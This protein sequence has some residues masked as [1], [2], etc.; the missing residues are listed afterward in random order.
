MGRAVLHLGRQRH[1]ADNIARGERVNLICWARSSSFRGAAAYGH[2]EPDGYPK[3]AEEG[4]PDRECLS[5]AN[6]DDYA[7]QLRA[8]GD[9]TA[10]SRAET[11]CAT[12][13]CKRKLL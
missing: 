10:A 9:E 2:I 13:A 3:A 5:L 7:Q 4:Q 1:G 8:L 6:D 11:G 12:G